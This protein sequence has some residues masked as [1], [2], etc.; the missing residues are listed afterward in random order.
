M[1]A[2]AFD[3]LNLLLRWVHL[4]TG[5]AWIGASFYFVWLDNSLRAPQV[6]QDGDQGV[7]GRLDAALSPRPGPASRTRR[8]PPA[9]S[10][11]S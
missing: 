7:G 9:A 3:W 8:S 2:Y 1:E 6:A 11:A 4:I 5:I 10:Q